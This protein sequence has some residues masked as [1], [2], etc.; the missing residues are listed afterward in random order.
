MGEP[1]WNS[2][3]QILSLCFERIELNSARSVHRVE[4]TGVAEE[5]TRVCRAQI[6]RRDVLL[7][8]IRQ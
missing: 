6:C 1:P 2:E 8:K 4:T 3:R 5:V 7:K